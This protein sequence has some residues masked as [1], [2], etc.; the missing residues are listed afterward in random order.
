M[1][2][3]EWMEAVAQWQRRAWREQRMDMW[4]SLYGAAMELSY[5]NWCESGRDPAKWSA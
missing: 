2:T 1:H 3:R 5:I 4:F